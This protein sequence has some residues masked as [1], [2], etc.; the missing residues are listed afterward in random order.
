MGWEPGAVLG[1]GGGGTGQCLRRQI[2]ESQGRRQCGAV[3]PSSTAVDL[4]QPG[5][6]PFPCPRQLCPV[7]GAGRCQAGKS[8][9]PQSGS[10]LSPPAQQRVIVLLLF[11]CRDP[12]SDWPGLPVE[13]KALLLQLKP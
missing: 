2:P 7:L 13:N 6:Q 1:A 12:V 3:P 5:R 4:G 10:L 11:Q 9:M 8:I